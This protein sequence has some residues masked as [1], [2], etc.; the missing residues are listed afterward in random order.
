MTLGSIQPLTEMSTTDIPGGKKRPARRANN[1][2][3]IYESE[4]VGASTSRNLKVLHAL[5][6]DS[7][8]FKYILYVYAVLSEFMRLWGRQ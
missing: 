6:R 1:L 2:T 5:Y 7:F 3:G 4:N 8:T